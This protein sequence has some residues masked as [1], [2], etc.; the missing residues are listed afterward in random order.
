MRVLVLAL[1]VASAAATCSV[2]TTNAD[3]FK[4]CLPDGVT[5]AYFIS[6]AGEFCDLS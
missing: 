5:G 3:V 2:G 6:Q 1:L 4:I